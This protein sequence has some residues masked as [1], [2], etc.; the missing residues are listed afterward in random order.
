[1]PWGLLVVTKRIPCKRTHRAA[2]LAN[3]QAASQLE[4]QV[5]AW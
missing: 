3:E 4:Q 5:F 1:M 2:A